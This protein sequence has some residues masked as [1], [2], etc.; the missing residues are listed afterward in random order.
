[1]AVFFGFR[2]NGLSNDIHSHPRHANEG[3]KKNSPHG[4]GLNSLLHSHRV[5]ANRRI[6]GM[7]IVL[8]SAYFSATKL[9]PFVK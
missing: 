4:G 8:A 3:F 7:E 2:L 5:V 1:V 6:D 9:Q